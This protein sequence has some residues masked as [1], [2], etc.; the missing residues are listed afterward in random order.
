MSILGLGR[1]LILFSVLVLAE[2]EK[3]YLDRP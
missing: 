3:T 2:N 1:D